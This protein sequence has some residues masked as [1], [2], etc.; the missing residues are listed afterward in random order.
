[1]RDEELHSDVTII[2]G[3]LAGVCAA[4]AAARNGRSVALINNRPVLGGNSSSEVRVWVV[5][6]T[7]HGFGHFAREGGIMGELF[8]ENQYRNKWGNPYLWDAL[9]YEKVTAEP[10]IRLFLNTDVRDVEAHGP[11]DARRIDAVTGWTMGSERRTTFTS[12]VFIDASGDGLIGLLAGAEFRIGREARAEYGESWAPEVADDV[13]LGS[14]LLFYT[15]DLGHPVR[16]VPPAFAMDV[17]ATTIPE[18]RIIRAGDDG[19]AYWWIET[20]GED[21]IV[22]DNESIRDELWSVV[23]GIWDYIKNSGKFDAENMTLEWV[24]SLPGKREYRRFVG[25]YTLTQNDIIEQAD[26]PDQVAFG[27]WSIDLHPPGGMYATEGG[28]K[29]RFADGVYPIPYRSLYSRNVTNLLMAGRNIS[30]SHVAFGSTRVMATCATLGEA[31]GT[32]AALCGECGS[33]PREVDGRR[34]QQRLLAHDGSLIGI[35]HIDPDDLVTAAAITASSTL[36]AFESADAPARWPLDADVAMVVPASSGNSALTL[37]LD[38]RAAT[39]LYYEAT[40]PH[41]RQNYV[42][43]TMQVGGGPIRLTAGADQFVTLP[44]AVSAEYTGNLFVVVKANAAV[45]AHVATDRMPGTLTFTRRPLGPAHDRPQQLREWDDNPFL[46]AGLWA[47]IDAG[48]AFAAPRVGDGYLRPFGGPHFWA[49][50]ALANDPTPWLRFDWPHTVSLESVE[51]IFDDDVNEDLVNLHHHITEPEAMPTLVRDYA[52]E[53]RLDG[54]WQTI[55]ACRDNRRRRVVHT[56]RE[57]IDCDSLRL[58]IEATNGA[59]HA[60][61]IAVRAYGVA[62]S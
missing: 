23:Y 18:N 40:I 54:R 20:G 55:V 49:S 12:P 62:T 37:K 4:I 15:K 53:S 11:G 38:V 1:M 58:R 60:H 48:D 52:L 41:R 2:G 26:Q 29:Q 57:P 30:A 36:T 6:A 31:A 16:F 3:G 42:P 61:V 14:T 45:A 43:G 13:T 17:A 59:P 39:E 8:V 9:L 10:G 7:A 50:D 56:F 32:A 34:L 44:L 24:G 19:C 35:R 51:F 25:D 22:H 46:G 47:R 27:G 5:G 33:D 28:T 21:D